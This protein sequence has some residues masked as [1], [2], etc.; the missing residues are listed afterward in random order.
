MAHRK[1]SVH[2]GILIASDGDLYMV[3]DE[4]DDSRQLM[5]RACG[6]QPPRGTTQSEME[7]LRLS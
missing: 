2:S 1:E 6:I 7:R 3:Q 4:S 5:R